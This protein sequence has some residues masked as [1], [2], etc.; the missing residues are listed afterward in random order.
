MATRGDVLAVLEAMKDRLDD[1]DMQDRIGAFTRTLQFDCTDLDASFVM[2]VEDGL[3]TSLEEAS[4][5]GPDIRL[6]TERDT[7]V[8][9]VGGQIN[10]RGWRWLAV[11]SVLD[12]F[13]VSGGKGYG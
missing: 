13:E 4:V 5:A 10:A 7:F 2:K 8:G 12:V 3:V 6:T 11:L 9:I 1:P